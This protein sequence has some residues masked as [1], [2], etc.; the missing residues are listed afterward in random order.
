MVRMDRERR[1]HG[2]RLLFEQIDEQIRIVVSNEEQSVFVGRDYYEAA[3]VHKTLNDTR[4]L[5]KRCK[6]AA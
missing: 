6:T 3:I 4:Y 5:D 1:A 2:A